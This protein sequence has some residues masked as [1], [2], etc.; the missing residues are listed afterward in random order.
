VAAQFSL[1]L[2]ALE[3]TKATTDE[4]PRR[5]RRE[6]HFSAAE[7]F[8]DQ[9]LDLDPTNLGIYR[10]LAELAVAQ[11]ELVEARRILADARALA[12]P[13]DSRFLFQLGRLYREAGSV[14]L[15]IAAWSRMD[16]MTGAWSCSS[17]DIQFLKWG[18]ELVRAGRWESAAKVS[19]AAIRATPADPRPY[20]LLA[21]VVTSADAGS[22]E[23][24]WAILHNLAQVQ[25]DIPW[26]S[27]EIAKLHAR[28]GRLE[29]AQAWNERASSIQQSRAW[30]NQ[31]RGFRPAR[32]CDEFLPPIA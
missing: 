7:R 12:G 10:N 9:A 5:G 19:Q 29:D 32:T 25:P 15:A 20:R 24:A 16:R 17:P 1:N 21:A 6:Q 30:A 18:A 26:P 28:A 14:D 2:G 22:D 11:S 23:N 3:L 31:R 4:N 27:A 13:D 8:L